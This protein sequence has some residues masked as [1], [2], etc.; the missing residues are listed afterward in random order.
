M[1]VEE[2]EINYTI[3]NRYAYK[4]KTKG[5]KKTDTGDTQNKILI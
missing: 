5:K 1:N 2:R 3:F 4:R